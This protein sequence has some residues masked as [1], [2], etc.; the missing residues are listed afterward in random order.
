MSIHVVSQG[1]TIADIAAE[2]G[3]SPNRL[4][5]DNQLSEQDHLVVGQALLVLQPDVIHETARGET[6]PSIAAQ[7][8]VHPLQIVRNN[9]FL[10]S[11]PFL[12]QGQYL[13]ILYRGQSDW[14]LTADGYAYPF[15]NKRLLGE[16]LPYLGYLSIFS[17]GFTESGEL[18]PIDDE[19]LLEAARVYG[20][21]SVFVLTP[22]SESGTFNS[23]L[24]TIAAQKMEVQENL[25]DNIQ[26][27]VQ[28]K[29]Y[30]EVDVDFEYI[31]AEDRLA[32]VEFVRRLTQRMNAIGITVSV[33]LA[34]KVSAD[35]PGLLYEG[36]DYRLLGEAAN[37]VLLMTYEWGYTY[38]HSGCR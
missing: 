25:I 30:S 34:P 26:R 6:V 38:N 32:H 13:V 23:N 37:S 8:G 2:Y 28:I 10:T 4:S 22:F 11:Q 19:P 20:T 27:T 36:V 9:P 5:F 31:R 29:G 33:A 12:R 1:E 17:Y 35:Q 14:S 16:T 15:I 7:Y 3:V 18:I 21:K 24:V